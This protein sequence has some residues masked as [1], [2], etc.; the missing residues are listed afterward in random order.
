MSFISYFMMTNLSMMAE[1]GVSKN[2]VTITAVKTESVAYD[3]R[4]YYI[5]EK[6]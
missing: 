1:A 4:D 6:I 2:S 5:K 3:L